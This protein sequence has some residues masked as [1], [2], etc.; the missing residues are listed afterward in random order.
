M[1]T[2]RPC[3]ASP[4]GGGWVE[5]RR[6][7][8]RPQPADDAVI[9]Y[10]LKKRH[11]FGDLKIEVFDPDG[12]SLGTIPSSKRRGLNRATWSMRLKPP[13]VPPAATAAF[14][15]A[16]GPRVLP[17]TYTVKLT[18]DKK[19]YTTQF[20]SCPTRARNTRRGPQGAVR[21]GA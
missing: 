17:G 15:A 7:V 8:R 2:A 18:K 11:I 3:K 12:K 21:S 6:R 5:R 20:K 13:Q 10:Y 14:G 9:T 4:R 19:V 16:V 1:A